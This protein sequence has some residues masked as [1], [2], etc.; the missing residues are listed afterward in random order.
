MSS[1][2]A[3]KTF[4]QRI[5]FSGYSINPIIETIFGTL[6]GIILFFGVVPY[7]LGLPYKR[8]SLSGYLSAIGL[9]RPQSYY[10]LVVVTVPCIAILFTS[11][12]LA[13]FV[14]AI[15][16]G[17]DLA[18]FATKIIDISGAIPP[19]NWSIVTAVGSIWEEVLIR[20]IFLTMLLKKHTERESIGLSALVFGGIHILNLMNGPLNTELFIGV[21]AQ[22]L[23]STSYGLFYG[24]LFVKTNNLIPCMLL[25]YVGN[26]FISFWWFTPYA[27]FQ[28]FTILMLVFYIGL[29]PTLMSIIWVKYAS[30]SLNHKISYNLKSN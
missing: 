15:L 25:H 23:W 24:Y 10:K 12:L 28:V 1:Y 22:I 13:S 9:Q 11:W 7:I 26:G 2:F 16:K 29:F 17:W 21:L 18:F 3:S 6:V 8:T 30:R 14:Y 20:G 27:S 4:I 5:E 19:Q